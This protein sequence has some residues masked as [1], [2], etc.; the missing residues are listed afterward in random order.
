MCV[1]VQNAD[2]DVNPIERVKFGFQ[3]VIARQQLLPKSGKHI[4]QLA[5]KVGNIH[6]LAFLFGQ[7]I[8]LQFTIDAFG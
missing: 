6:Q 3:L 7:L 4:G 1:L 8:L 2:V 5:L